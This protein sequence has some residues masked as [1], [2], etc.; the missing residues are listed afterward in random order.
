[1]E[2]RK[3]LNLLILP[4]PYQVVLRHRAATLRR[5]L[6][7][8]LRPGYLKTTVILMSGE[9]HPIAE[10]TL[11]K[12]SHHQAGTAFKQAHVHIREALDAHS[13]L[14]QFTYEVLL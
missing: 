3:L 8:V 10:S 4:L 13:G 5:M 7:L 14:A 9:R 1:M 11:S 2:W 6:A 12:W